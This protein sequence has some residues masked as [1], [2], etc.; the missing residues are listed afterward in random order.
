MEKK[1]RR[2]FYVGGRQTDTEALKCA[3]RILTRRDH[4]EKELIEKLQLRRFETIAIENALKRCREFGYIDDAKAAKVMAEHLAGRGNGPLKIRRV[5][6]Q[7]GVDET[8]IEKALTVCG[9]E[10][11]QLESA[12]YVLKRIRFRLY[13]ESDLRKRRAKV[14]RFLNGRGFSS[15][16]I[17]RATL[18]I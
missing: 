4:T 3:I 15:D 1:N 17:R 8:I 13:R 12:L 18:E 6:E 14:Y 2:N 9:D 11:D 16:V 10:D 7:K 5:L